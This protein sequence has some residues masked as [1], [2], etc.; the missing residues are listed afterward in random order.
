MLKISKLKL[1]ICVFVSISITAKAE[2]YLFS[3]G[4]ADDANQAYNYTPSYMWFGM[5]YKNNRHLLY[6]PVKTFNYPD[7]IFKKIVNIF[8]TS[9]GQDNEINRLHKAFKE[10]QA[11]A[12]KKEDDKN[13][14]L[15]GLSRGAS[16]AANFM[17]AYNP[18]Q[19]KALILESPIDHAKRIFDHHWFIKLLA[20]MTFTN[21]KQI[22]NFF[23]KVAQ[24][25]ENGKHTIDLIGNIKKDLPILLIGSQEDQAVP[26]ESIINLYKKLLR[27]GHKHVY[28][29][30]LKAGKHSKLLVA[31]DGEKYQN[32]VHAFYKKYGLP[33]DADFAQEGK[34]LLEK[35][36]PEY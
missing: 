21:T 33:H 34:E 5:E 28:L 18:N 11:K 9:F 27:S 17:A 4:F 35:C 3:H 22:Y 20:K 15:F 36:Q 13:I 2:V 8:K 32:V 14:V 1:C 25:D 24:H 29:L 12:S 19:V 23:S 10:V 6:K 31:Q 26:I 30:K 16:V 7:V